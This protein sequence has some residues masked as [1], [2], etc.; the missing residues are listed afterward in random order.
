MKANLLLVALL[1]MFV[2]QVFA[3]LGRN[4]PPLIAPAILDDLAWDPA[5]IGVY[6]AVAATGSFV[7]QLGCGGFIVRYGALRMSQVSLL[8]L[9]VGLAAGAA[10]N[11][12]LFAVSAII[13][14]GGAAIST[15]ASS[16]LLGRLSPARLAPLVFSLKQTAVPAGLLLCGLLGPWMVGAW[17]WRGAMLAAAAAC[18][19]FAVMLEPFRAAF[20]ADRAPGRPFRLSDFTATLAVATRGA[21]LRDLSI[22]CFAFN[23]LQTVFIGYFVTYL[24]TLGQDL[25]A[26]GAIFSVAMLIAIPGRVVWGWVGSGIAAPGAVLGWLAIGMAASAAVLALSGPGWPAVA[27]GVVAT[28]LSATALSWHGVLLSEAARLAPEGMRGFAT[29]GVL[30]FGQFG[31]LVMPLVYA[32][33]LGAGAGHG[34]GFLL[35]GLP[36]AAVGVMLLRGARRGDGSAERS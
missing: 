3:S 10:G 23:G 32:V 27:L 34:V 12:P 8:M 17:G 29:G 2:Q 19:A 9:A 33:A 11:L 25:V 24:T 22:A 1:T 35:A 13:G 28:A 26:A 5:W 36:C 18:L 6:V 21:G 16:H 30:S 15:P 4:L 14:G 20:D 7:F 31:G